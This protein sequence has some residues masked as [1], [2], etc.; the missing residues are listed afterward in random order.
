MILADTS[1]WIDHLRRGD[2]ILQALL[3]QRLVLSHPFVI[4]E[5]AMGSMKQRETVLHGISRLTSATTARH[6]EVMR[7]VAQRSL[8]GLG[9]GY[10]DVHLILAARLTPNALLWTR[11]KRLLQVAEDAQVAFQP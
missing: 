8:F 4:G 1:I 7:F 10:I 11:D 5:L 2:P 9:L 6:D 3:G